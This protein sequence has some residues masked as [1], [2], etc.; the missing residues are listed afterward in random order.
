LLSSVYGLPVV[1]QP[2]ALGEKPE[3]LW[4]DVQA[5]VESKVSIV[6]VPTVA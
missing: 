5:P 6:L 4:V 3:V 1:R 2:P